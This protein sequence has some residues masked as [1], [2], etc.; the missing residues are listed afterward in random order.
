MAC[1]TW[2]RFPMKIKVKV[3][4]GLS[5]CESLLYCLFFI[6]SYGPVFAEF[7]N[8]FEIILKV[9]SVSCVVLWIGTV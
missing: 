9:L 8:Y 1:Y 4:V 3:L 6:E 5:C 7:A 2:Y